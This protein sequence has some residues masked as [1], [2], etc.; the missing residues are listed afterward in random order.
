MGIGFEETQVLRYVKL[1]AAASADISDLLPV[2]TPDTGTTCDR[3]NA[4]LA[5]LSDR[6]QA[7]AEALSNHANSL[8]WLVPFWWG[9]DSEVG[10]R[11]TGFDTGGQP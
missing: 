9:I 11:F 10:D 4:G 3:S 6:S 7:L 1:L 8:R 5:V 2:P